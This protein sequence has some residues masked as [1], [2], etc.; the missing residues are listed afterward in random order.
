MRF[1]KAYQDIFVALIV[2][3][4][5]GAL[6]A[7]AYATIGVNQAATRS[8]FLITSGQQNFV[9]ESHGRCVGDLDTNLIVDSGYKLSVTGD[10][11]VNLKDS[12]TTAHLSSEA[13]FNTLGQ[14]TQSQFL[15]KA[16]DLSV[17]GETSGANPIAA[18][19][20]ASRL[21]KHFNYEYQFPGPIIIQK[22][23]KNSYVLTG[24]RAGSG[25]QSFISSALTTLKQS[26]A[27]QVRPKSET[28]CSN[29]NQD[30]LTLQG[31]MP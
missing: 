28:H 23:D 14:L 12:V 17:S 6:A 10:I 27:L 11:R 30:A 26:L 9:V 13:L 2:A 25:P 16:P 31:E 5:F 29:S 24:M 8:K 18:K 1:L 22:F 21:S 20:A 19:V 7:Y 4:G 15:M 3:L